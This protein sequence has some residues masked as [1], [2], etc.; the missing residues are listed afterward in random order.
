MFIGHTAVALAAKRARPALPLPALIAAAYGP[1]VIEVTLLALWHWA[2]V[3]AA[4][5]SHSIPSI[6][7]GAT[8]VGLAYAVW[9]RDV[10][11]G[12]L[13]AAV[14]AS[15]WVAD[16]FTGTEKPTWGNGPSL[17]LALYDRPAL[18]F[19]IET[20]LLLVAWLVFWP[21]QDRRR[22]RLAAR[23]VPPIALVALQLVF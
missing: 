12:A 13:L 2:K 4:F 7:L 11:G 3:P 8:V 10:A 17:G 9:R 14:Y 18:D 22:Q 20:A 15:H 1:D 21:A 23:A 19:A 6:L 5:G 16:L